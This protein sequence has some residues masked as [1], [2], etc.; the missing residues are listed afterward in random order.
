MKIFLCGQKSFGREVF[1]RLREDGHKI[2][3]VAVAPPGQYYDKLHGL[4]V[5]EKV[6]PII[7]SDKL[8]STDIPVGT[9]L[10]VAAHSHHY[11][12]MKSI[13]RA[14]YG[15]IGYHPSLLPRHRGRDAVRWAV[16]M[17][18]PITGGS[19]YWLNDKVD[20][21]PIY[22]QKHV[23]INPAWDYH[24][25]WEILFG[26]GVEMIS[27]AVKGIEKGVIISEPQNE[28]YATWEPSFD[29]PRLYRPELL[30]LPG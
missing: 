26:L 18:D 21:G 14:K 3:G 29:S 22:S 23:F 16:A 30:S 24:E 12:S 15:A 25:L 4:A 10:I 1:K 6:E 5:K 17:K 27:E 11:I 9:D 28:D 19:I 2:T 7:F 13:A 8:L 20:G